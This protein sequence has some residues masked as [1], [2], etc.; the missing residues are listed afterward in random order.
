M[1]AGNEREEISHNR[2][3]F[4]VDLHTVVPEGIDDAEVA[5]T[6]EREAE[7]VRELARQGALLRLWRPPVEPGERRALGLFA[8]RG[9]DELGAIVGSLPLRKWMTVTIT[10]LGVHPNDPVGR[11]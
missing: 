4:L 1:D 9:E 8:A 10:P 6:Y 5:A 3:E 2:M 11:V 7:R